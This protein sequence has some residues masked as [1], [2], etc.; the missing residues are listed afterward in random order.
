MIT[1]FFMKD[2]CRMLFSFEIFRTKHFTCNFNGNCIC[3]AETFS[4]FFT[5]S[6]NAARLSQFFGKYFFWKYVHLRAQV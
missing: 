4:I 5:S 3:K 6:K 2:L 1:Y